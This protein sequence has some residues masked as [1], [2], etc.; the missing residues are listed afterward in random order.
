EDR[1]N[2]RSYDLPAVT[3]FIPAYNEEKVIAEKISNSLALDYP[4]DKLEIVVASDASTDSTEEE[5]K[6]F[7]DDR[8]K[9]FKSVKRGG[10]NSIINEFLGL[11]KGE[12]IIF[13]DANCLFQKDALKFLIERFFDSKVGLVVG[14]LKYVD[15]KSSVGKGEGLYFKYES[16]IKKMESSFGTLVAATGSIYAVRKNLISTLDLDVANDLAHPIQIASQGYKIVFEERA[17]A[18]EKATISA[19]EEFNRRARIVTRGMTAFIRYWRKYGMLKGMW[20]FCFISH[21]LIRWF[22]PFFLIALFILNIF[23]DSLIYNIF[24]TVQCA[25]YILSLCGFF[26]RKRV[27][28]LFSIPFYFVLINLAAMSGILSYL[29]GKRQSLWNVAETT[30]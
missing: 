8:V 22:I 29:F 27:G 13:T 7:K 2:K 28:K 24:F 17:V 25:F 30:R 20:G 11:C 12:I 9:F 5:V 21:K 6:K 23:L 3:L 26:F 4:K 19:R 18:I 15:E 1:T 10:K 16:M 14:R